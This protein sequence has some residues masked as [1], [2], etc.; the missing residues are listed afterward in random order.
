MEYPWQTIR[1]NLPSKSNNYRIITIHGHGS[2]T[3]TDALKKYEAD[4]YMQC[5]AYRDLGIKDYFKFYIRVFYPSRR[6][7]LD[8]ALKCVLDCLQ[9]TK[10]IV[11]DNLCTHI[12]A[13]KFIDKV[14]P[15]IE[16]KIVTIDE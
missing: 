9:H 10:T 13:D 11:N 5:G 6:T 8:N 16:F 4:F 1:G 7:D 15:R 14:D 2:L 12:E 3:K